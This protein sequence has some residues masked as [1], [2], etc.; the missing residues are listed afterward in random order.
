MALANK[1]APQVA[2]ASGHTLWDL[3]EMGTSEPGGHSVWGK[4]GSYLP[5]VPLDN[6]NHGVGVAESLSSGTGD[7]V[8]RQ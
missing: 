1:D 8:H 6:E 7:C 5:T 2:L 3:Y 4:P